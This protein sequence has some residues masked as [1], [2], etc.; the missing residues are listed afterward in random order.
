MFKHV[1]WLENLMKSICNK[2]GNEYQ[3]MF[4]QVIKEKNISFL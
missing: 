1:F 3:Q 2:L 4:E